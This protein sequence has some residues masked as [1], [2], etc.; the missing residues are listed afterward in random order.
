LLPGV[1]ERDGGATAP[2]FSAVPR[3]RSDSFSPEE[4]VGIPPR[5]DVQIRVVARRALRL[6]GIVPVVCGQ[7]LD[8]I[9]HVLT[10]EVTLLH[11][12]RDT[13]CGAHFDEAA[14]M[15][16]HFHTLAV[17][18]HSGFLVHRR[19]VVAEVGLNAGNVG[20]LQHAPA[21]AIA[22]RRKHRA[23]QADRDRR[24]SQQKFWDEL[25]R[26]LLL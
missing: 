22:A 6:H 13:R 4:M 8:L 9:E 20:D 26:E 10:D 19:H 16:E 18:H 5:F 24:R 11:P 12:P 17:L 3:F 2:G 21:A 7:L 14:V 25:H 23:G 15:V 1:A